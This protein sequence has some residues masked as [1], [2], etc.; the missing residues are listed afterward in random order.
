MAIVEPDDW[1]SKDMYFEMVDFACDSEIKYG[2][3]ID[4]VKTPWYDVR[5]WDDKKREQIVKGRL[6]GR[7]RTSLKPADISKKTSLL[8]VHPSIWSAIY[9]RSFLKRNNINFPEYPG[10]GWADNPFLIDTMI[11]AKSIIY[12]NKPFYYYRTLLLSAASKQ[13][14][15]EQIEMPFDRWIYMTNQLKSMGVADEKIWQAHYIRGFNYLIDEISTSGEDNEAVQRKMKQM[16]ELMDENLVLEHPTLHPEL[17]EMYA[18]VIGID[19][20]ISKLDMKR[21]KFYTKEFVYN[22]EQEGLLGS[23]KYLSKRVARVARA[24]FSR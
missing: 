13:K 11:N 21:A 1:V 8:E 24:C 10:A 18:R 5:N 2:R 14:T 20:E 22:I 7:L 23:V 16:F 3:A 19:V 9:R 15:D 12:L 6:Y 4:I 17:K